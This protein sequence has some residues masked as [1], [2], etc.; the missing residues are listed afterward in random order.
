MLEVGGGKVD[1]P[2][3]T[4]YKLRLY[5]GSGSWRKSFTRAGQGRA[6]APVNS[7]EGQGRAGRMRRSIRQGRAGQM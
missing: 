2:L 5:T 6:D 1:E 4:I 7:Q 3:S